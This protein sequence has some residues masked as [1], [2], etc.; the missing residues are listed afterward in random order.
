MNLG[1]GAILSHAELLSFYREDAREKRQSAIAAI[2][3]EATRLRK[4]MQE[5]GQAG[6]SGAK[7]PAAPS[8]PAPRPVPPPTPPREA[9]P[10]SPAPTRGSLEA[11]LREALEESRALLLQ[12]GLSVDLRIPPGTEL[13]RCP[14]ESLRRA[15]VLLLGGISSLA[16]AGSSVL[17]RSERKPVLLRAK[18]GQQVKRDFL[19]IAATHGGELGQEQ[20]QRILQGVDS[21]PMGEA[22][23]MVRQMGGFAR[24]APLPA[25]GLE[26]RLFLPA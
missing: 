26:T 6:S 4:I 11:V 16:A 12:R 20:Q 3:T 5:L 10:S 21:S 1:L 17:V 7:A 8:R 14:P 13:P 24:F 2:Q 18:D 25:G 23:R 9:P 22:C 19:M 15:A